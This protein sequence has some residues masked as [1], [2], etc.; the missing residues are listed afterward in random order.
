MSTIQSIIFSK[1]YFNKAQVKRYIDSHGFHTYYGIDEKKRTYRVRQ[2]P[3]SL[4]K[5]FKISYDLHM[6]KA[7]K[8]WVQ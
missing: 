7:P 6:I 3:P 2:Q 4:F 8:K 1:N 5:R